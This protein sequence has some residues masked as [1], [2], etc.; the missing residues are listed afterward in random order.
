MDIAD[1]YKNQHVVGTNQTLKHVR[2]KS[3]VIVFLAEDAAEKIKGQI[4]AECEAFGVQVK[5]APSMRQLGNCCN[6]G[7]NAACAA[8]IN[9]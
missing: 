5:S 1:I 6:I 3:A 2:A 4:I 8:V 7:R 9:N